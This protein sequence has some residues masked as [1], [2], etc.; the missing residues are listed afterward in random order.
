MAW[1]PGRSGQRQ[2]DLLVLVVAGDAQTRSALMALVRT[3]GVEVQGAED[4]EAAYRLA[5]DRPPDLI[6]CDLEMPAL[7]GFGFIRRLRRDPRFPGSW[8]LRSASRRD[9]ST[10][11]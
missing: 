7:D 2:P 11:R 5:L 6:L 4:G 1:M 9:P 8:P 10:S 3:F